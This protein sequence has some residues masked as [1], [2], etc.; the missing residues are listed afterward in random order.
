MFTLSPA[1][2]ILGLLS[3]LIVLVFLAALLKERFDSVS[4]VIQTLRWDNGLAL[5]SLTLHLP[6]FWTGMIAPLALLIALSLAS[7]VL[8]YSGKTQSF[9]VPMRAKIRRIS[10]LLIFAG[11]AALF[12]VP[13]LEYFVL[14]GTMD[15][16]WQ[17]SLNFLC[18][19]LIGVLCRLFEFFKAR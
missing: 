7:D 2:K 13:S 11:C 1:L 6:L 15:L 19:T 3:K 8:I 14:T 5:L 18:I 16:F 17:G 10:N 4:M 9:D 12:L